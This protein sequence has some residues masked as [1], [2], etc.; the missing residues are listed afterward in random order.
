MEKE[1][2]YFEKPY[3]QFA[4]SSP[5]SQ[6]DALECENNLDS[7]YREIHDAPDLLRKSME[8]FLIGN[9]I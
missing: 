1:F 7:F 8:R 9:V 5:H 6:G 4:G 2:D 3:F